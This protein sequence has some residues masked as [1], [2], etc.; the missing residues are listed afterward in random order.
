MQ[1]DSAQ[2]SKT[3][4]IVDD[5]LFFRKLLGTML[6]EKGFSVVAEA[7]DGVEAV[8]KYSLYRPELIILDIYMPRKNGF[9][10]TKDILSMNP[11][12]KVV[13][14]SGLGYDEDVKAALALGA[15]DVILKPFIPQEVIE[16]VT[17]VL[18]EK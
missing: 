10:A 14:C 16:I 18:A 12:A 4:L 9:D 13:I 5:E 3:V 17:R 11:K 1:K 8:E 2:V 7:A 6:T 15:R